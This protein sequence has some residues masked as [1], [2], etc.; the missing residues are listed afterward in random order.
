MEFKALKVGELA[1]RTGVTVRTLHHYDQIGLLKP[2]LRT[3]SRHRLYSSDDVVRLQQVVS[4]RQLDLS[5]EEIRACLDESGFSPL[6]VIELHISRLRERIKTEHGLCERLESLAN[7][8]RAS[9]NVSAEEF[10][11]TI[12]VTTMIENYYTPEQM[13]YLKK[14]REQVGEKRMRQAP[15][16]WTVL[17]ADFRAAMEQGIDPTD[18]QVRELV[19]RR[20]ALVKEFTGSDPGIEQSLTRLWK[21]QGDKL[22]AQHGYDLSPELLKYIS[23]ATTAVGSDP[24]S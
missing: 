12:E 3:E 23:Q 5:L 11:Q 4:L 13:E 19:K 18:P 24:A 15:N 8:L 6:D 7:H 1:K 21:D 16:D 10:L 22:A 20:N 14:R 2:S 17:F 9:G